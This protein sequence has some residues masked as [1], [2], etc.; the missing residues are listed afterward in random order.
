MEDTVLPSSATN[1]VDVMFEAFRELVEKDRILKD[2]IADVAHGME[3]WVSRII[4]ILQKTHAFKDGCDIDLKE[5]QNIL[6]EVQKYLIK[7]AA[8]ISP[9]S[10]YRFYDNFRFVIQKL[11]FVVTYVHFLKH[12]ILLSRD[13][14]AEIL[15]IKVDPAAGFHLDVEDYLFGVLQLANELSRFSINAVVVG[16][17]V[18]PFKRGVE[19][20]IIVFVLLFSNE[21]SKSSA[22]RIAD[23]LYDLDAKFRLLNLKND[24]LRRRYDALKYDVQRAEQVVYDLTI[25]GLK[26]PADEKSVST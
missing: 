11:C 26:R 17:S 6:D 20:K 14:V 12:G 3:Y 16:N 22:F 13:R 23:F 25:R 10:Y 15:N 1:P 21:T 19:G 8:L 5:V 4:A 2:N 9:V 7:L 24:G 18:L